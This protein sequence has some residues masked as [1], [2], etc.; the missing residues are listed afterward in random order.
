MQRVSRI[1][2]VLFVVAA[3]A[4]GVSGCNKDIAAK[5]NG[6]VIKKSEVDAQVKQYMDAVQ[7]QSQQTGGKTATPSEKEIHERV[8]ENLINGALIRQAAAEEGIKVTQKDID[9]QIASIRKNFPDQKAFDNA[10][11]QS[12]MTL[13]QLKE[14]IRDQLLIT[15]LKEKL[16]KD[17]AVTDDEIEDYYK[18][19]KAQ[20]KE[21]AAVRASHILFGPDDKKT[22][23]KVLKEIK[24]GSNFG[25]LA[26]KY[27]KDPASAAKG[28]DLGWPTTPYV[29]EFQEACDK[30]KKGQ[31]SGLVKTTYGWHIIKVTDSRKSRQKPVDEVRE[32][33]RQM[34][35]AQKSQEAFTKLLE[36][37][38]KKAQ[39]EIIDKS[40]AS[41]TEKK[42]SK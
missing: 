7:K 3:L 33:V 11:K 37:L 4:F 6:E 41:T 22:A 20:F 10:L 32:Q 31:L 16:T 23:E 25:E 18:N 27:S 42:P 24:A 8:V 2:L 30:L 21:S 5:V 19:N 9:E 29:P 40:G 36:D 12:G 35:Q 13:E 34:L 26:K 17:I 38:R 15:R 1:S 28:G 39:I 14:Q